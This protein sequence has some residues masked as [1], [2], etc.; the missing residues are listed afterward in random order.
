M[1]SLESKPQVAVL[2]ARG[3]GQVHARL[4]QKLGANICAILGS[5]MATTQKAAEHLHQSLGISPKPFD[6]LEI[7]IKEAQPDALSICTPAECHF[8][9]ILTSFDRGLPVFCEKPLFWSRELTSEMLETQLGILSDHP[10][11]NLLVNT[12][13]AYFLENVL[14]KI[15]K[16]SSV[17][18]FS[19]YFYTQGPHQGKDIA[20]DL[21]PHG[22]SLLIGLL[23]YKK[24]T[25]VSQKVGTEFYQCLFNYGDCQVSFNFQEKRN[26]QKHFAFSINDREFTRGQ[27]G[28]GETYRVYLMDSLTGKEIETED[29]F[30][31]YIEQFLFDLKSGNLVGKEKFAEGIANLRM[32]SQI[33]FGDN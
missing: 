27:E 4:F 24:I 21:L 11:S 2:G 7:L 14:E 12:S 5:T 23:G 22:L 28:K 15:G 9:Q 17:E 29:P 3:I 10:N 16:P 1:T 6:N 25:R 32:M 26:G 31:V 30:Q 18:S 19:F 33:Y 13:N 20:L 8:E